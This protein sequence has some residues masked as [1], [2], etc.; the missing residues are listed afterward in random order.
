MK[1]SKYAPKT[2]LESLAQSRTE[3]LKQEKDRATRLLGR[4]KWKAELL[5]VSYGKAMEISQALSQQ[6]GYEDSHHKHAMDTLSRQ[7]ESMFKVDFF[8]FYTLL[9]R[10]ITVCLGVF[11]VDI[12]AAAPRNN[13]NA[14]RYITNPDL[15]RTRPLAS[16]AFHANLLETLDDEKCPLHASL[17]MQDVRIQLGLA[18][19]YRN[20]WKDADEKVTTSN[21][22]SENETSRKNV[23]LQDLDLQLML[24]NLVAGCE[25]AHGVTQGHDSPGLNGTVLTSQPFQPQSYIHDGMEMDD[26]PFEYMD[27]AMDLD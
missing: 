11:G 2:P 9:E 18:K 12:S 3:R 22:T 6:N 19:D 25:H 4:L 7:A 20:A 23:E 13:V 27:D 24:E 26:I 10:Y 5:M 17:G 16:H 21:W 15:H 14:L 8:E 1:T